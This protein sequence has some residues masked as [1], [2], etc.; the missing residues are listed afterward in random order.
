MRML[1][2]F[3]YRHCCSC[4]TGEPLCL[5]WA[6]R[7]CVSF[8]CWLPRRFGSLYGELARFVLRLLGFK[9]RDKSGGIATPSQ[10]TS[11]NMPTAKPHGLPGLPNA[12]PS[13]TLGGGQWDSLWSK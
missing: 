6:D 10:Q 5:F 13:A 1:S 7:V 9:P 12:I 2:T 3:S 4:W 11:N 8:T